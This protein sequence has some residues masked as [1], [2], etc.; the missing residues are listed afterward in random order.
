MLLMIIISTLNFKKL[1]IKSLKKA[2]RKN[3]RNLIIQEEFLSLDEF[4]N[5]YGISSAL[6]INGFRQMAMGNIWS[7]IRH[8]VKVY[9]ND[10][11]V[12]YKW[13]LNEGFLIYAIDTLSDDIMNRSFK[14]AEAEIVHNHNALYTFVNKNNGE[15]FITSILETLLQKK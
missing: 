7:D 12:I 13:L 14:L 15:K 6:V 1:L 4:K 8:D 11:N 2:M 9:L 3:L 10:N 5:L